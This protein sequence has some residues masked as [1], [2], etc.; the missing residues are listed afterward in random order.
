MIKTMVDDRRTSLHV[1]ER[2]VPMHLDYAPESDEFRR[3]DA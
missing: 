2:V 1:G 3:R